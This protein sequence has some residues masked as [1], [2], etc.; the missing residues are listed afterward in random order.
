MQLSRARANGSNP[1]TDTVVTSDVRGAQQAGPEKLSQG[2]PRRKPPQIPGHTR[3]RPARRPA[4]AA[5]PNTL[6]FGQGCYK[7]RYHNDAAEGRGGRD[8]PQLS[9]RGGRGEAPTPPWTLSWPGNHH[10]KHFGGAASHGGGAAARNGGG[11][12]GAEGGR[13]CGV[14]SHSLYVEF[15]SLNHCED[16]TRDPP[17][18]VNPLKIAQPCSSKPII[19]MSVEDT[20]QQVE[21]A[22][23]VK[24][25]TVKAEEDEEDDLEAAREE[26]TRTI[27]AAAK[28]KKAAKKAPTRPNTAKWKNCSLVRPKTPI[29]FN[30]IKDRLSTHFLDVPRTERSSKPNTNRS[31]QREER[32][33]RYLNAPSLRSPARTPRCQSIPGRRLASGR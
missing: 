23:A 8:P 18:S 11:V 7:G 31:G 19:P 2:S 13:S 21:Q 9:V 16:G 5:S 4:T 32:L 14:P 30:V 22:G 10:G 25:W 6:S 12:G 20:Q 1:V 28:R 33:Q 24:V 29:N 17:P 26:Y 15:G 3:P 27:D